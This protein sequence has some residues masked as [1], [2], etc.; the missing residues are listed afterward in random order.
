MLT[1]SKNA[2]GRS[3][4]PVTLGGLTPPICLPTG[5][6]PSPRSHRAGRSSGGRAC[7]REAVRAA[8]IRARWRS[9]GVAARRRRGRRGRLRASVADGWHGCG[10]GAHG[11]WTER[12]N[13]LWL[14]DLEPPGTASEFTDSQSQPSA[15]LGIPSAP[16]KSPTA[17]D[18]AAAGEHQHSPTRD[19]WPTERPGVASLRLPGQTTCTALRALC[20]RC[21]TDWPL[22][23]ARGHHSM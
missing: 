14:D 23:R 8:R 5:S 7:G 9:A 18:P 11:P 17:P 20:E 10:D 15:C 22:H 12:R 4:Q 16:T 3:R 21:A 2:G 19:A 13:G 1:V 6:A